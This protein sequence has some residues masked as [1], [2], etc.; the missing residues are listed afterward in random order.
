MLHSGSSASADSRAAAADLRIRE[1][2]AVLDNAIEEIGP[3][4]SKPRQGA[5]N[6]LTALDETVRQAAR[7]RPYTALAVAGLAGFVY[8]VGRRRQSANARP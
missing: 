4:G 8:A 3:K 2:T 7:T 5:R 6:L 1:A